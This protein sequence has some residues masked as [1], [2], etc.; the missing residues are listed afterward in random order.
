MALAF[1]CASIR[2]W[3]VDI[4]YIGGMCCAIH[5]SG[6]SWMTSGVRVLGEHEESAEVCIG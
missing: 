6:L 1:I 3:Y 2:H 4:M 5:W